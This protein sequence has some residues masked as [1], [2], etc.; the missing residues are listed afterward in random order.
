VCKLC[1]NKQIRIRSVV[2]ILKKRLLPRIAALRHKM[3]Q[4]RTNNTRQPRRDAFFE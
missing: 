2:G 4:T 1:L 3:G